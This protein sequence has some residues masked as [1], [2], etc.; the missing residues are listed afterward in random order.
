MGM[1]TNKYT[2][3]RIPLSR[4]VKKSCTSGYVWNFPPSLDDLYGNL[5]FHGLPL[6]PAKN[7]STCTKQRIA[8][9]SARLEV[10]GQVQEV[11]PGAEKK[12]MNG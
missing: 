4:R 10:N 7:R 6:A 11:V 2:T 12:Q 9:A 3:W 5:S 1:N 8:Q